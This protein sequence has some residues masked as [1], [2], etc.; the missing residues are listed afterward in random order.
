MIEELIEQVKS[1]KNLYITDVRKDF[2]ENGSR[3]FHIHVIL[4]DNSRRCFPL[5]LP[6]TDNHEEEAFIKSF[7]YAS[8]HNLISVLGAKRIEIYLD[9]SDRTLVELV[10]QLPRVFGLTQQG[11]SETGYG[12]CM[13]VNRQILETIFEVPEA[14]YFSLKDLKEEP[15]PGSL[16]RTHAPLTCEGRL[17]EV[18]QTAASGIYLGISMKGS[19]IKLAASL[20]GKLV[21]CKE[22]DWN[23]D[24][25]QTAGAFYALI[26]TLS[27]LMLAACALELA[28][29]K[30]KTEPVFGLEDE[31]DPFG[32]AAY[33]KKPEYRTAF[34]KHA[35]L[36]QMRQ[37]CEKI[38]EEL[39]YMGQEPVLFDGIG[40]SIQDVVIG[41]RLVGIENFNFRDIRTSEDPDPSDNS[42][43]GNC[44]FEGLKDL[45]SPSGRIR[46]MSEGY[47][48]AFTAAVEQAAAGSDLSEGFW[49]YLLGSKPE[50]GWIL[51]DGSLPVYPL[52]I[53][54]L[55][56]D[57]GHAGDQEWQDTD[58]RS[59]KDRHAHLSGS[60]ERYTGLSG[61]LRLAAT[62]LPQEAPQ[63]YEEILRRGLL[64]SE[65]NKDDGREVLRVPVSPEDKQEECLEFLMAMA[66]AGEPEICAELFRQI[67]EYLAVAWEEIRD[68][69]KPGNRSL[70]LFG[71]LVKT[72]ECFRLISEGARRRLPELTLT[73]A[74]HSLAST[75]LMKQ[76]SR[77]P[78]YTVDQF[79]QCIG[80]IYCSSMRKEK[81]R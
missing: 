37:T 17:N 81:N 67:G 20:D 13:N 35:S 58:I 34:R 14:F 16:V 64:A 48:A 43:S 80:G 77:H 39:T 7:V 59:T 66:S 25:V 6:D 4:F 54:N 23:L 36:E 55:I 56:I 30:I 62:R 57:L 42:K 70:A 2:M 52:E 75:P 1:K 29:G 28:S 72:R 76:L 15:S 65:K 11:F 49:G 9:P 68:L 22:F 32:G 47:M 50:A 74:E 33:L 53:S 18:S 27:E 78:M 5:L 31:T 51:P 40:F 41:K 12:S 71:R 24:D 44:L 21:A 10:D 8:I 26:H 69:I 3:P 61:L 79:G 19:D 46:C 45:L 73:A 60:L 63:L 38:R